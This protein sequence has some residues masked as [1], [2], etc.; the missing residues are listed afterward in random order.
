MSSKDWETIWDREI[1]VAWQLNAVHNFGL[2]SLATQGIIG[3]IDETG[4]RSED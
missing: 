4:L 2:D 3:T 1:N